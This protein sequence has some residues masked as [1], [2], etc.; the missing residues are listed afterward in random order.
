MSREVQHDGAGTLRVRFP[1]DRELVELIKS[2]AEPPLERRRA[3]LVGSRER[4]RAPRRAAPPAAVR[5]RR[6]DARRSTAAAAARSCSKR[7]RPRPAVL[8]LRRACSTMATTGSRGR[9]PTTPS[10]GSTTRCRRVLEAAFPEPV[11]LVGEISGFNRNAHKRHVTFQLVEHDAHGQGRSPIGATLFDDERATI[12]QRA[13][14]GG[15]ALP[16]RGR[17]HRAR[18]RRASSC[19]CPGARTV[20]S[21]RSSTSATRS[22]RRRGGARRSS[23]GSPRRGSSA[24]P[25]AAASAVLPLRVGLVTS[26]GSDAYNDVLRT[27]AG[28]GLRLRRR[29][30]RRARPGPR[31][32][33][34]RCS[35]RS[36]VPRARRRLRRRADLPRRR[37]AD[38]PRLVRL[39][40]SSARAVAR[41][42]LP[43][44]VGIGHEQDH[45]VLDAVG[46]RAKTP[47]AAAAAFSSSGSRR[48]IER[49]RALRPSRCWSSRPAARASERRA[50]APSAP[51]GS[52]SRRGRCSTARRVELGSPRRRTVRAA[53][54]RS[55]APRAGSRRG[56]LDVPR[57]RRAARPAAARSSTMRRRLDQRRGAISRRAAARIDLAAASPRAA[58]VSRLGA[59]AHR[60][61]RAAPA[62]RR[63][64]TRASSAATRS[65]AGRR[66]GGQAPPRWRRPERRSRAE[67]AGGAL[68]VRSDGAGPRRRR[69]MARS[70]KTGEEPTY[71]EAAERLEEILARIEEG[72]VDIDELSGLVRGGRRARHALPRQDPRRGGPGA[73]DHRAARARS[74]AAPPR[75]RDGDEASLRLTGRD[76]IFRGRLVMAPMTPRHRPALPPPARPSGAPRSASARWPTRTRSSSARGASARCC[77]ATPPSEIFG[78][79]LAGKHPEVM[80]EAARI[81]EDAGAD[82]VDVN[83]GCPIDDATRRGFGAALLERPAR[84]A[85]IVAAM[86]AAV[87]IPVTV[88]LRLGWS[89]GQ[90][91]VPQGRARGR[92]GRRRCD[93]APRAQPRAALPPARGLGARRR[94]RRA[95][96]RSR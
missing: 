19:T 47:T 1:F 52:R 71:G 5:L 35:T 15:R 16:L 39:R 13:A 17:G 66:R 65:C 61:A 41:F 74:P 50:P 83:L 87:T 18:P 31:R 9:P 7:H 2:A 60:G 29:G 33:S 26:L 75:S 89:D 63:P 30:A 11:W 69:A 6:G 45:S 10:R 86:K 27:L 38:R 85:A 96:A 42:P 51:G 14:R 77:G 92:R 76:E 37:L 95:R 28:V 90:A 62:P 84:V 80:A 78:V 21:S 12:E 67:L 40:A 64:A 81:A 8:A 20:S 34:P 94:A 72:Q 4:R 93:H 70:A 55:S 88:K 68:R 44:V 79:Q 25:R 36:M 24:Q 91:D 54:A 57:A 53:R 32:P 59:R 56:L 48:R 58:R 22:A 43:V 3:L 73:D 23:A 46:R 49:A 82:F